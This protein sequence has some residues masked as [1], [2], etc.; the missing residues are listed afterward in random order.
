MYQIQGQIVYQ[1]G[2]WEGSVGIPTFFLDEDIQGIVNV[3]HALEIA[4]NVVDPLRKSKEIHLTGYNQSTG[5]Y[6][7]R[8]FMVMGACDLCNGEER[9]ENPEWK[10]D[11]RQC[12][13][14]DC[15]ECVE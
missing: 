14:I 12:S 8:N 4:A 7:A 6:G 15:P 11:K 3:S 1:D 2:E 13:Y 9:I 10:Y 5:E